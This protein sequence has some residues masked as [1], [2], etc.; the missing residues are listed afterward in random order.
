[1]LID[2]GAD[3]IIGNHPHVI[4]APEII[5]GK[6]V[7]FSLGN[8]LFDQK[9]PSTKEGLMVECILKDGK[10]K[11]NGITTHTMKNSYFPEITAKAPFKFPILRTRKLEKFSGIEILPISINNETNNE[12]ILEGFQNGKKLWRTHPMS[13]VSISTADFDKKYNYLLT[14]EKHYSPID[15]ENGL[16]PYVYSI[17]NDGLIDLWRGSAL[18]RPLL[19]ATLTPDKKHLVTLHR[20]DSFINL[21][22]QNNKTRLE[23]Y[24]WNGFGFS[25]FKDSETMEYAIKYYAPG[26]NIKP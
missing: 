18:S 1:M 14:L 7:F 5:K 13:L 11:F 24:Q 3:L 17:T 19:D 15:G 25:G 22:S 12:I 2:N 21:D 8:H 26:Q 16:R 4:Q 10:I 23:T 6:P 20:G 9:Y